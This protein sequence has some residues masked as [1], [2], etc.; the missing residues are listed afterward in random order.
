MK[1]KRLSLLLAAAML[2]LSA[3]GPSPALSGDGVPGLGKPLP[4]YS[5]KDPAAVKKRGAGR[6]PRTFAGNI[7]SNRVTVI[8]V[9]DGRMKRSIGVNYIEARYL[10]ECWG[11]DPQALVSLDGGGSS[12]MAIREGE[13]CVIQSVPSDGYPVSIER[14]V[15]EALQIHDGK[16]RRLAPPK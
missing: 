8:G 7:V 12:V 6:A 9:T 13:K 10:L 16:S 5:N 3:C 14:R 2:L 4:D 11:C 1:K 15:A